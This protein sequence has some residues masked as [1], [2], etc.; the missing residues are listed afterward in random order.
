[1]HAVLKKSPITNDFFFSMA[2]TRQGFYAA[3][4]NPLVEK[5]KKKKKTNNIKASMLQASSNE[6]TA[7]AEFVASW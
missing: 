5:K 4:W 6:Q 1:M 2:V 3:E 7:T